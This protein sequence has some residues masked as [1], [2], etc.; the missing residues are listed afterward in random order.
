M[1]DLSLDPTEHVNPLQA[2]MISGGSHPSTLDDLNNY[3]KDPMYELVTGTRDAYN[4]QKLA[5]RLG[6]S[7]TRS[8]D[9]K[10]IATLVSDASSELERSWRMAA[11]TANVPVSTG[12]PYLPTM[13]A[14]SL[15]VAPATRAGA[16]SSTVAAQAPTGGAAVTT[17]SIPMGIAV[18]AGLI[19]QRRVL[20]S[21]ISQ[22]I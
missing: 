9:V 5:H 2:I 19:P 8:E 6:H 18:Y 15:A 13:P 11:C 22:F 14:G 12:Y 1:S 3:H 21:D 16:E 7:I 10:N 20:T 17:A 4:I